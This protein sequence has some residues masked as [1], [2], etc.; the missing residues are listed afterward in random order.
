MGN[1]ISV[2]GIWELEGVGMGL[3]GVEN[4]ITDCVK[5]WCMWLKG[6]VGVWET[7]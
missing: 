2:C 5:G 6:E 4:G 1:G 7:E 3:E